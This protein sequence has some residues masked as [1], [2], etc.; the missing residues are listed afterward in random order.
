M[1]K[2][3]RRRLVGNNIY[4]L[5][6]INMK[7]LLLIFSMVTF[8]ILITKGQDSINPITQFLLKRGYKFPGSAKRKTIPDSLKQWPDTLFYN[9]TYHSKLLGSV[10]IPFYFSS[11]EIHDGAIQLSPTVNIGI[12]Y[13]W[14]T[15]DFI[16]NED[17]KITVNPKFYF[18]LMANTGI[19]NGLN[20]KQGGLF[21]GGFIGFSAFTL[22]FG[23]DIINRSPAIGAGGR[24]DFYTLSQKFLHVIGKVKEER[25]H[26]AIAL[27]IAEE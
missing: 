1:R 7:H 12:G 15:G 5:P 16:F 6:G 24:I 20:L 18:G 23:Y 10:T 25:K 9:T 21:T 3:Q 19:Q 4:F 26:R 17:D 14:F 11:V 22:I 8:S 27:P 2:M 13:T